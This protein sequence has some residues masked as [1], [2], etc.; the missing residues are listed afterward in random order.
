MAQTKGELPQIKDQCNK[1]E[2]IG[3]LA[4]QID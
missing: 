4:F 1:M 2:E 3:K